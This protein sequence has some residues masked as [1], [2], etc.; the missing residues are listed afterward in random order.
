MR[1]REGEGLREGRPGVGDR[2]SG[3]RG[4]G[5]R[6]GEGSEKMSMEAALAEARPGWGAQCPDLHRLG[7][8]AQRAVDACRPLYRWGE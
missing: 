5:E 6:E 2:G 4:T 1:L 3:E 8:K 7:G